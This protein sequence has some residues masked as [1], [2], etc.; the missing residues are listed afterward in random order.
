MRGLAR[1]YYNDSN[2]Q[3]RMELICGAACVSQ[4]VHCCSS[5]WYDVR[6]NIRVTQVQPEQSPQIL[7][8]CDGF[9]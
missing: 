7:E 8:W 5:L 4:P 3:E 1:D 6:Q 9:Q 2:L